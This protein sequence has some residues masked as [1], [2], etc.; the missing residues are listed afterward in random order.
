MKKI[1]NVGMGFLIILGALLL[2]EVLALA[3]VV[4]YAFL[5]NQGTGGDIFITILE[6]AGSQTV[7]LTISLIGGILWI[8]LFYRPYRNMQWQ[9][10]RHFFQG[11]INLK[12]VVLLAILG[13]SL[14]LL[15]NSILG[16]ILKI[17]PEVL[18]M[19]GSIIE[20]LGMGSTFISLIYVGIIGPV[21]EELVFRG[22][23]M[24]HLKKEWSFVWVNIFQALFFGIYHLN[25]VQGIYAFLIGLLL[26]WV[27]LKYGS[28]RESIILHM[29]VNLSGCLM[30]WIMPK[31]LYESSLGLLGLFI[32]AVLL[33]TIS[34][35]TVKM[36]KGEVIDYGWVDK[37]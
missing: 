32:I 2:R 34:F 6:G 10:G 22:F 30:A 33:I 37:K 8:L 31:S 15:M 35:R 25:M 13:F 12:R 16:T 36:E 11:S 21:A 20:T 18:K 5:V 7:L 27:A 17:A 24:G 1:G 4:V 9:A 14:Q 3:G 28:I 23:L 26:G 19:Y 29:A